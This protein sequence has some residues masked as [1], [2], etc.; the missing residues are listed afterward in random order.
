[1]KVL[2]LIVGFSFLLGH[3]SFV[4]AQGT[5]VPN[6]ITTNLF[7]K[8]FDL[9]WPQETQVNGFFLTPAGTQQPSL[10]NNIF[11][12]S[13]PATIGVRV[14]LVNPGDA[15]DYQSI[16]SGDYLELT[17][18]SNYVFQAG[19]PFYVGLYS[20]ASVAPPYPPQPPYTYLDPVFGWAELI[21]VGGGIQ[22]FSNALEYGGDGIIA[23]TKNIIQPTPEPGEL[24]LAGLGAI[25]LGA[26]RNLRS[27]SRR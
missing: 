19:V 27:V 3:A 23:G 5:I 20:G 25:V 14:F 24:A 22:L 1:M 2:S 15:I 21:N 9:N 18:G 17:G 7:A 11:N 4:F 13:E 12:F 26:A 16:S 8:E 10:Y 6:G